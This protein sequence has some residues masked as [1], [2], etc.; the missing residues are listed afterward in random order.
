MLVPGNR[1]RLLDGRRTPGVIEAVDEKSAMFRWRITAF[2]DEG[3]CWDMTA[4]H[5]TRYQFA[6][7]AKRLN[8]SATEALQKRSAQLD[9]ELVVPAREEDRARAEQEIAQAQTEATAWLKSESVFLRS[10]V[11]LDFSQRQGPPEAADD[12]I[13]FMAKYNLQEVETRTAANM[14]SNPESGEWV[15]GMNI[16]LAEMGLQGYR[17]KATRTEDLFAGQGAKPERTRYLIHRLAFLRAFFA[18]LGIDSV[19][20]FRGA[21]MEWD[22]RPRG[23]RT[24]TSW[25]FSREVA[26]SFSQE[27]LD[28]KF[29]HGYLVRRTFPVSKLLMTYI[30]T[31]EMNGQFKEA[32]ALV[33]TDAQDRIFW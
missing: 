16:V 12:F 1:C 14:V 30:E 5:V 21:S 9:K 20:L 4:E 8:A 29:A 17:G 32:E 2:E 3:V 6:K 33:L 28:G 10:G 23:V 31:A 18:S 25:T 19:S 27:G 26:E 15:K 22:W 11:R 24:F 13:R 7:D